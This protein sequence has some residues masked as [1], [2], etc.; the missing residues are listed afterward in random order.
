MK[1]YNKQKWALVLS[2]GGAKGIAHI[3]VLKALA[4]MG[5]PEP[6]MVVGTS[7]GSIVGGLYACGMTPQELVRFVSEEFDIADYLDGFAFKING[8][9]GKVFQTGQ[10]LSNIATKPGIDSGQRL[11]QLFERLTEGKTF[12]ETR[13]PF[14][15]NAVDL[16]TGKEIVF[17]TGSVA[18]AI[19]AS[20]SFPFF[21]EPLFDGERCLVDG[22][23]SD[24]MPVYI[25]LQEGVKRVLAVD[26]VGFQSMPFSGFKTG[27]QL[28][29]RFM[30]TA[31]HIMSEKSRIRAHLTL[32][33]ADK[34]SPFNFARKKEFIELGERAVKVSVKQ[35]ETFF[36]RD[37]LK[38][39]QYKRSGIISNGKS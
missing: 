20:M 14:R 6:A 8:P 13:I 39:K 35:I 28:I 36:S 12:A 32:Y 30:E 27:P 24:N 5:V 18:K 23:L 37:I 3:G 38:M 33:A 9:V 22:G 26:V 10:I 17:D 4:D 29:Y 19:R 25:P 7:M 31:M 15:C 1:H 16:I 11:L 34:T 21:F 2:G